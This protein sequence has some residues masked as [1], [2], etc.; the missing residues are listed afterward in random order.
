MDVGRI[1][2]AAWRLTRRT[3]ALRVLGLFSALQIVLYSVIVGVVVVPMSLLTQLLL[4]TSQLGVGESSALQQT[5]FVS[6]LLAASGWLSSHWTPIVAGIGLLTVAWAVSGVFDVAATAGMISQTEAVSQGHRASVSAGLR[7]GFSMWWRA[8]GLLAIAAL[9]SLLLMLAAAVF[10]LLAVSLPLA[11]GQAPNAALLQLGNLMT[12]PLSTVVSLANIPLAV[13]V[14]LGLRFA[15]LDHLNWRSAFGSAWH[16]ARVHLADV[17][18]MYLVVT[19]VLLAAS[20][21]LA[22]LSALVV[23]AGVLAG[24]LAVAAGMAATSAPVIAVAAATGL[25]LLAG[26]VLFMVVVLVWQSVSWTLF[27]RRLTR[28][29]LLGEAPDSLGVAQAEGAVA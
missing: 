28:P 3:P 29:I 21:G 18:V 25:L 6:G 5:T 8:A 26:Y 15:V 13:L 24:A 17:A 16:M 19:G 20:L 7:E 10:T 12:T 22:A 1:I 23:T 2:A 11:A 4:R 27:W 9:P 14:T